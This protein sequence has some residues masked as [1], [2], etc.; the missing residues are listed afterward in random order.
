[1]SESDSKIMG[2]TL[3]C[4]LCLSTNVKLLDMFKYRL[5]TA[6][7]VLTGLEMTIT[8]GL[9]PYVCNLCS[10]LLV[11]SVTFK[12]MCKISQELL[13]LGLSQGVLSTDYVE[14]LK[15][16][17]PFP[18]TTQ[19]NDVISCN[20]QVIKDEDDWD[21]DYDQDYK[22]KESESSDEEP[23]SCK[24]KKCEP[25][26]D[27][28]SIK[29]EESFIESPKPQDE[30]SLKLPKSWDNDF[31]NGEVDVLILTKEEQMAEVI[32]RRTSTNYLNSFYKCEMCYKGFITDTTYKNHM[33]RHDPVSFLGNART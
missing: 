23:L 2:D 28:Q 25:A 10:A 5:H 24:V 30:D 3:A 15:I 19:T 26:E 32:S 22:T 16:L 29:E 7:N 14:N 9:P 31:P 13:M 17:H 8:D 4:R 21:W 27:V 20:E 12:R 1:M 6:Y 33:A 18:L 11:K